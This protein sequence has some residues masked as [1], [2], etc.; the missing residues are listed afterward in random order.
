M[1]LVHCLALRLALNK[2]DEH[3]VVVRPLLTSTDTRDRAVS[4]LRERVSVV[5]QLEEPA[6]WAAQSSL[7]RGNNFFPRKLR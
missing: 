1:I 7:G 4:L 5:Y 6:S 2:D 3:D